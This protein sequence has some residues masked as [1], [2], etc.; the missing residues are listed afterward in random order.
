MQSSRPIRGFVYFGPAVSAP[1]QVTVS[2]KPCLFRVSSAHLCS[3]FLLLSQTCK[4]IDLLNLT[5]FNKRKLE[6]DNDE[7]VIR[8]A[9]WGCQPQL[10]PSTQAAPPE[11]VQREHPRL[12][13]S[14]SIAIATAN[15]RSVE[16][17]IT[18]R[19]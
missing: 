3:Q 17:T 10:H 19:G 1:S 5:F 8:G 11:L 7:F 14:S 12:S 15:L 2:C 9:A 6:A 13:V 16:L 18:L 4:K